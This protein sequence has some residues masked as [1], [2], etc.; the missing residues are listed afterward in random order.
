LRLR[1]SPA[2][3]V[4]F[5]PCG[6][7]FLDHSGESDSPLFYS[8]DSLRRAHPARLAFEIG[9]CAVSWRR[10]RYQH[11]ALQQLER[12]M[13]QCSDGERARAVKFTFGT[14]KPCPPE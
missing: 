3:P 6:H 9:L 11:V 4:V 1:A 13:I 12:N 2:G 14:S 10:P 7:G 8:I 5:L